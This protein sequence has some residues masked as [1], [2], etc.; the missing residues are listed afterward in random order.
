[1]PHYQAKDC[2]FILQI[3]RAL[4]QV[5]DKEIPGLAKMFIQLFP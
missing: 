3:A 2:H 5:D 1:M 4:V